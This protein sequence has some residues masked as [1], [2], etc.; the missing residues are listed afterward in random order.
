MWFSHTHPCARSKGKINSILTVNLGTKNQLLGR[1]VCLQTV[2]GNFS[3]SSATFTQFYF[4]CTGNHSSWQSHWG[5]L[6]QTEI[7]LWVLFSGTH[8]HI[9]SLWNSDIRSF[10]SIKC[11][12]SEQTEHQWTL[13]QT[14]PCRNSICPPYP[15]AVL[16]RYSTVTTGWYESPGPLWNACNNLRPSKV[17]ALNY[18]VTSY[19]KL[20]M[21]QNLS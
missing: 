8:V 19:C 15:F 14:F 5:L 7:D 2:K 18:I 20:C 13:P 12:Y 6:A 4:R 11:Y 16:V 3:K 17:V 1:Q 10:C 21:L 9:S